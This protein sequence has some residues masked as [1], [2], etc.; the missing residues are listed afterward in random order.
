MYK[1]CICPHTNETL[2]LLCDEIFLH[3]YRGIEIFFYA[4]F[5]V[6]NNAKYQYSPLRDHIMPATRLLITR[7]I[8]NPPLGGALVK[9]D[10][11]DFLKSGRV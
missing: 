10:Y 11:N 6:L 1:Y 7:Y 8:L 2:R 4:E 3:R 5:L 9:R